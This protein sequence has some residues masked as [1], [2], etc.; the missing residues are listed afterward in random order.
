ML[1]EEQMAEMAPR[2]S[3]MMQTPG[4]KDY[5]SVIAQKIALTQA[6]A[7]DDDPGM[8]LEHRGE[9]NGLRAAVASAEDVISTARAVTGEKRE[10]RRRSIAAGQGS[11][12]D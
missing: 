12:F 10:A 3:A 1:T 7:I 5:V 4:W 2:I 11:S 8:L 6:I 9:I